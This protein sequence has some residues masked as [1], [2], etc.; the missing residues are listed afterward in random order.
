MTR[1]ANQDFTLTRDD[2]RPLYI[3]AGEEIPAEYE[4]H[5]WVLLHTDEAPVAAVEPDEKRKPARPA[6]S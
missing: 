2:C 5:W 6:K 4:S 3:K 1:I